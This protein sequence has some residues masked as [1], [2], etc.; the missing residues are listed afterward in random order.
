[1]GSPNAASHRFLVR[2]VPALVLGAAVL[3]A[4][5][6]VLVAYS[7]GWDRTVPHVVSVGPIDIRVYY[8][9][10][11][12]KLLLSG[13]LAVLAVG[14][15]VAGL[16]LWAA[17]RVT[18]PARYPADARKR[19]LRSEVTRHRPGATV[20]ITAVIPAHDEAHTLGATLDSLARQTRRP[21]SVWVV[22]DNCTD[23]TEQV[24]ELHGARVLTTVGNRYRKAGALNQLLADLLPTLGT[25][26]VVLVMDA[27]TVMSENFLEIAAHHLE[28]T[29]DLDAVGGVFFGDQGPG[30]LRQLQRN[31]YVRYSRDISRHYE[32]VFVLTG[33]ASL[34]RS[35]AL[36]AVAQS[37]GHVLPGTPGH[38]YDTLSLTEDNEL[39]LAMKTLGARLVSPRECRVVTELMP[40][41]RD[42]WRQRQRWQRGALENIGMYGV[43]SASARY[44][45][46]Q[47]GIGYGVLALNAYFL[48]MALSVIALRELPLVVFWFVLG[49]VFAIERVVT[50]WEGGWRA[51]LL[52]APLVIELAYDWF[53][54]MVYVKSLLDIV[55]GRQRQWNHVRYD[56]MEPP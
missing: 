14:A 26:D 3:A 7:G 5:A 21:A 49:I 31:E 9:V 1:V 20:D 39:T 46:Q 13:L 10:P 56:V 53:L 35:D 38:V 19:L 43:T 8:A 16:D 33:T 29:P 30:L 41:R 11:T 36:L 40:T 54:Q 17:R 52:A 22:A 34:F 47:I 27:D 28:T 25:T 2:A 4:A 51:R 12:P 37:R 48:V 55:L 23:A 18:N 6:A 42:L 15:G 44:W 45:I 50:V 24:A 32:R